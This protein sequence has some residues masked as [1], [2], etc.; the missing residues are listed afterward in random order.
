MI[1][2]EHGLSEH[3]NDQPVISSMRPRRV[4]SWRRW[5]IAAVAVCAGLIVGAWLFSRSQ[6][7]ARHANVPTGSDSAGLSAGRDVPRIDGKAVAFSEG[8]AKRAGI[9]L[10]KVQSAP[11]TP[12]MKVVGTVDFNPRQ[13]AAVGARIQGFVR[14]VFKL[15]GDVVKKGDALAEIES[16]SLGQAQADLA[17]TGAHQHAAQ[18]NATRES[19][20]LKQGLTTAREAEMAG[21]AMAA[22]RASLDAA[23]QRVLALGGRQTGRLGVFIMKAPLSGSVVESHI[24]V[25]QSVEADLVAFRVANLDEL[26]IDLS[27]F[28]R[29]IG[30]VKVGDSVEVTPMAD[31]KKVIKGKVAHVSEIL[32]LNTRSGKV[33]VQ[34][35]NKN[36][37]LRPGQSVA[38]VIHTATPTYESLLVPV[39][40][41]TYIDGA[42]TVFVAESATRVIP[43][44]VQL[45]VSDGKQQEI[46]SG[47]NPGQSVVSAGVFAL[48]S[49]LF[50]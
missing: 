7:N 27:V 29:T 31:I 32:D 36:R 18:M 8:F 49:E 20:L 16:A 4:S 1:S 11:L 14:Q 13:V 25:G 35:E 3:E 6:S 45:G 24:S 43:T 50:R 47:L 15:P 22:H 17:A 9:K 23:T 21:A 40:A 46:L 5:A 2:D 34:V 30:M 38:A 44:A 10:A 28:E 41:I 33:R 12:V 37:L 39:E 26:W 42:P 48:K 19:A